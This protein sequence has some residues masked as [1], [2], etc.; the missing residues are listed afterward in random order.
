MCAVSVPDGIVIGARNGGF[1]I[2]GNADTMD[3]AGVAL[4]NCACISRWHIQTLPW[5]SSSWG[6]GV[7]MSGACGSGSRGTKVIGACETAESV[8]CG[9]GKARATGEAPHTG[10]KGVAGHSIEMILQMC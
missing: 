9:E 4:K 8:K 1:A 2:R 6:V 10:P 7:A 3:S 5:S